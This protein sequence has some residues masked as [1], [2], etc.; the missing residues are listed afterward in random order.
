MSVCVGVGVS[1]G[2]NSKFDDVDTILSEC[3]FDDRSCVWYEIKSVWL[4]EVGS[5]GWFGWFLCWRA[6]VYNTLHNQFGQSKFH[7]Y[8]VRLRRTFSILSDNYCL[9]VKFGS[10]EHN[11]HENV[12]LH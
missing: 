11:C 5:H 6:V 12:Y 9:A 2:G 1:K 8:Y 4:E 3:R 10:I 7:P